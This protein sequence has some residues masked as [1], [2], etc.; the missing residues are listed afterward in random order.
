MESDGLSGGL[1]T[2]WDLDKIT[3]TEALNGDYS[4]TVKCVT[5]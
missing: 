2:M 4:L 5:L 1:L 3:V